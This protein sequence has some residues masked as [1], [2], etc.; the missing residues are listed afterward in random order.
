MPGIS[1]AEI[2]QTDGFPLP[3]PRFWSKMLL[4]AVRNGKIP[5]SGKE[6]SMKKS[7][8]L[9]L[10]GILYIICAG[11]GFIPEPESGIRV[12]LLVIS[13]LFFVPPAMVLYDASRCGDR[14]TI[15]LIRLLSAASLVVTL[16]LMILS[17][18]TATSGEAVGAALH[19][20]LVVLSAPML[21]SNYWALSLF[22]WAALLMASFTGKKKG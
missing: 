21:C 19:V 15:R 1:A 11:L 18:L 17:I 5:P 9:A 8:L 14:K 6:L 2:L 13:L 7:S 16:L 20:L 3:F 12:L 10:W 22:L 4:Y